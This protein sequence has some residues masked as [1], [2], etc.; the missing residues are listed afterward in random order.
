MAVAIAVGFGG[1]GVGDSGIKFNE[2]VKL[3]FGEDYP[4]LSIYINGTQVS[5]LGYGEIFLMDDIVEYPYS[6]YYSNLKSQGWDITRKNTSYGYIV[7]YT[8]T[9]DMVSIGLGCG[10]DYQEHYIRDWGEVQITFHVENRIFEKYGKE[11]NGSKAIVI[12]IEITPLKTVEKKY[13]VLISDFWLSGGENY[14][15]SSDNIRMK[16]K[17]G[18]MFKCEVHGDYIN[19]D[20]EESDISYGWSSKFSLDSEISELDVYY[21]FITYPTMFFVYSYGKIYHDPEVYLPVSIFKSLEEL[22]E[23]VVKNIQEYI[24]YFIAGVGIGVV[25]IVVGG[26]IT[27]KK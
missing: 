12:D 26:V 20:S 11:I 16:L 24:Q 10:H 17:R 2:N 9:I 3:V 7:E 18:E 27:R 6:I 13:I 5:S 19:L 22:G 4:S 21:S 15:I 25:L 8:A 14:G 23:E 1:V